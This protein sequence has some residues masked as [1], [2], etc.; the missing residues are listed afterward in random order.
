M[1]IFQATFKIVFVL[2]GLGLAGYGALASAWASHHHG[3]S[4]SDD[5]SIHSRDKSCRND[6]FCPMKNSDD[7]TTHKQRPVTGGES[8]KIHFLSCECGGTGPK[9]V[10]KSTSGDGVI[11]LANFEDAFY[12]TYFFPL[13][14][15]HALAGFFGE[16]GHPP[17][18]LFL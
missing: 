1:R 12:S 5:H 3:E 7:L 9:A 6:I 13:H 11:F 8:G 4:K 2:L 18:H 14:E 15:E 17:K 10:S 16:P